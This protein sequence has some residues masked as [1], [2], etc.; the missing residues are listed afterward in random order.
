MKISLTRKTV[1]RVYFL[2]ILMV[3]PLYM[4]KGFKQILTDKANIVWF[5]IGVG[6]A[7]FLTLFIKEFIVKMKSSSFKD[8]FKELLSDSEEKISALDFFVGIFGI[9]CLASSALSEYK[10]EALSGLGAW[11]VGGAM[12]VALCIMYFISS[13][14]QPDDIFP[15][16]GM[17]LGGTIAMIIAVLN[18]LWI[19]PLG[20]LASVE[21]I[22]KNHYTSTLG[23]ANQFCGY[24]SIIIPI[25]V[26]IFVSSEN[27]F[28][29]TAAAIVLFLGYLNV[30]LT[31]ADSIYIGV[32]TAYI[33]IVAFCLRK[34]N[35]YMGLLISGILFAVAGFAARVIILYRPE[36]KLDVVSPVL[37]GHNVHMVVGGICFVLLLIHMA[38]ELKF[39]A[40]ELEKIMGYGLWIY[41]ACVVVLFI[42][43]V[44][45]CVK[46]FDMYFLNRRGLLWYIAVSSFWDN[47]LLQQL[48]GIGP[49]CIDEIS[50]NFYFEI[51][52]AYGDFY[53][54]DNAHND[55]IE[56]LLTTGALGALSY[57][58]IY[59]CIIVDFLKG[60]IKNTDIKGG[61]VYASI[62]IIGYIA[63]SM[64]NGPHP[65]TTAMLFVLLA[66]WR[67]TLSKS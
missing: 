66:I 6:V 44:V 24:L 12:L 57:L 14:E 50:R 10:F 21:D 8:A 4:T 27:G 11:Y 28:K 42:A 53:F 51:V 61:R 52:E 48:I 46:N 1:S 59:L 63:Q 17:M 67:S 54:L 5:S 43:V 37:L 15:F 41:L 29:R 35:R 31:H 30:F 55:L 3:A 25:M 60:V 36:I 32:G 40:E 65:L 23:N 19:D 22:W 26:I 58:G 64:M 20:A 18:D 34:V 62:G 7:M 45:H 56:Y 49:G 38:L 16:Y 9:V 33:F 39:K 47:E 2:L 13:K